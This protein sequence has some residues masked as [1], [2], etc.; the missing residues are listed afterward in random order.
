MTGVQ[1]CALPISATAQAIE[2]IA[3]E[4]V[5][6]K[7]SHLIARIFFRGIYFP[8]K[9]IWGWLKVVA[10][11]RGSIFRIVKESFTKWNGAPV[12][13]TGARPRQDSDG[14]PASLT[15]DSIVAVG[16]KPVTELTVLP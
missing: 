2:S 12:H 8:P 9:G 11:N 6:Y 4:P 5:P 14:S 13:H 10:Q 1:T 15:H 7:I 16:S 3:D